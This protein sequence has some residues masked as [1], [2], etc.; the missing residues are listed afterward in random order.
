MVISG[1]QFVQLT[2]GAVRARLLSCLANLITIMGLGLVHSYAW[3]YHS[4]MVLVV[5]SRSLL[6]KAQIFVT[7]VVYTHKY[8]LLSENKY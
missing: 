8:L 7:S 1:G 4:S 3:I 6:Y 5:L 2:L